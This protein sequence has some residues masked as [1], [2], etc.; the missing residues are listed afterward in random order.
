LDG[1]LGQIEVTEDPDQ[2]RDRP[3]LLLAEQ[4]LDDPE[5]VRRDYG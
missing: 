4:A 2:G 3:A 5:R 1:V